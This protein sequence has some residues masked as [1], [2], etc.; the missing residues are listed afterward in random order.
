MLSNGN[1]VGLPQFQDHSIWLLLHSL[2]SI[3]ECYSVG[4]L[5]LVGGVRVVVCVN[6][7]SSPM[8]NSSTYYQHVRAWLCCNPIIS[9]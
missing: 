1:M 8:L 4:I 3:V 5:L 9:I 7:T 2:R 6:F